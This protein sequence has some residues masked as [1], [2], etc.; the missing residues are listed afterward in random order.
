MS[1]LPNIEE[2]ILERHANSFA[3]D[4]CQC[5]FGK[6]EV[7]C[8]ECFQYRIACPRCFV[9][10]HHHNPFHWARVWDPIERV[11][12]RVDYTAVLPEELGIALPLG[13][14]GAETP[15]S[16]NEKPQELIVAHSN[17]VHRSRVRF[18][19]CSSTRDKALQLTHAWLFPASPTHPQTAFTFSLLK[20]FRVH[21]LQSK[22][23]AFDYMLGL[24]RMSN[25][26][27]THK[28]PVSDTSH[29]G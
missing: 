26:V 29:L 13:H 7:D 19:C 18:C 5:G 12:N 22:A 8:W 1:I 4:R 3:E 2:T 16:A 15:C 28:V 27:Q 23:S 9:Q 6:C 21:N 17:G 20:E 14:P 10:S 25:S 11:Y 24:R